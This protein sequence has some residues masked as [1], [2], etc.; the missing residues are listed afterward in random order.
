[1]TKVTLRDSY[2][3]NLLNMILIVVFIDAV[4]FPTDN[5]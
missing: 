1:M 5:L 4:N 3:D 2:F